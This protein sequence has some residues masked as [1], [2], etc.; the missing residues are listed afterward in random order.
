M[1]KRVIGI[2]IACI[3]AVVGFLYLTR[4]N[5]TEQ[6][7][8]STPSNHIYGEGAKKV[9]LVEYGD[10]QCPA[11]GQYYPVV[12]SIKDKYKADITFQF[13]NFPIESKHPNARAASRAAEAAD[14]QG[15]FWEMHDVLYENQ[16]AWESAS[17]PLKIFSGYAKQIGVA[18]LTKFETDYKSSAVNSVINADMKE[19]QK[20]GIEGTPTFIID[21][22]KIT[23]N[24]RDLASFE[25]LID[26]AIAKKAVTKQ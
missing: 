23:D 22:V 26:D 10:F 12:K 6:A 5:S 13:R 18:D 15:K 16:T 9:T 14:K 3:L 17:D 8:T 24:P 11:C 19:G 1:N 25:K 4:P 21:G 2:I 7:V 20:A